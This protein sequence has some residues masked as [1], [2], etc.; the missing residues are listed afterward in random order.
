MRRKFFSD[1]M[2]AAR[3]SVSQEGDEVYAAVA[4]RRGAVGTKAGVRCLRTVWG[5]YDAKGARTAEDRLQQLAQL[6]CHPSLVV[7]SGGGYH[8]Y[9]LLRE[10][11]EAPEQLERAER[12]MQRLA[13]RLD[14]D[15]VHDRSRILRVP[16][17]HNHKYGA[18]RLA[19]IERCDPNLRYELDELETMAEGLPR[20]IDGDDPGYA[21]E[22]RRDILSS[23][24]RHG[25]RNVALASVAGSLRDR[26]LDAETMCLVLL[27]VNRLR[28][29]PPLGEQEVAGIARSVSKYAAGSPRYRSSSARRVYPKEVC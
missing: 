11:A 1:P 20:S 28:C 15:P 6:P 16:G 27:E 5:D 17:T 12:V 7:W 10:P 4:A 13:E 25:G 19:R 26:G 8:G 22:V 23:P 21:G 3:Y 18:P 24:I 14:G 9:W 2:E 29:E